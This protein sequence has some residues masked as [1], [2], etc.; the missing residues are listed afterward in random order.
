MLTEVAE[1]NLAHVP[2]MDQVRRKL[3]LEALAF[4]QEFLAEETDELPDDPAMVRLVARG[5]R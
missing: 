5:S 2:Q 4:Y 3:L 1:I